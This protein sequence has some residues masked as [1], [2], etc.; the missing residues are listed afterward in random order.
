MNSRRQPNLKQGIHIRL[1]ALCV[2]VKLGSCPSANCEIGAMPEY[3]ACF[4]LGF[5]NITQLD[6]DDSEIYVPEAFGKPAIL[7][8]IRNR[9]FVSA[10]RSKGKAV[11]ARIPG[12]IPRAEA[13]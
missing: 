11:Q 12:R 3:F 5:F 1:H 6:I 2:A 7:L 10:R 13:F 9:L 8:E 4:Y